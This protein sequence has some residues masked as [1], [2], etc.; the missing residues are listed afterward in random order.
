MSKRP[1]GNA[2]MTLIPDILGEILA[3]KAE[4]ITRAAAAR[5]L[6]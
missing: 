6:S 3:A 5:P 4:E 2:A 1:T